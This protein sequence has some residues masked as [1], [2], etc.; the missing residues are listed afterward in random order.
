MP[1]FCASVQ[2]AIRTERDAIDVSA[3]EVT[4]HRTI[5]QNLNVFE[6]QQQVSPSSNAVMITQ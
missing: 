2:A 3:R 4:F 1:R 5:R 6:L